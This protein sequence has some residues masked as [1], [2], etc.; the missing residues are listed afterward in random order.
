M[1]YNSGVVLDKNFADAHRIHSCR[2]NESYKN[3]RLSAC[4][5][6]KKTECVES[7]KFK[8]SPQGA[9]LQRGIP[10]KPFSIDVLCGWGKSYIRENAE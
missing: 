4:Q 2:N 10:E 1:I 5:T 7:G 8:I 9:H 6:N 3:M